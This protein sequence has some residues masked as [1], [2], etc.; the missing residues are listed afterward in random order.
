MSLQA[1]PD[2]L[3]SVTLD[4]VL[5]VVGGDEGTVAAAALCRRRVSTPVEDLALAVFRTGVLDL[6]KAERTSALYAE[7]SAWVG[8]AGDDWPFAFEAICQHFAWDPGAV[9]VAIERLCANRRQAPAA[10]AAME[11]GGR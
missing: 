8:S 11:G 4:D 10:A 3:L 5:S 7:A 9:R 2:T 1:Y 6:L